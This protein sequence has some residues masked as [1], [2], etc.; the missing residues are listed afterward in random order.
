MDN[1]TFKSIIDDIITNM[2]KQVEKMVDIM[3]KI[4]D[5]DSKNDINEDDIEKLNSVSE[6]LYKAVEH[7]ND[8]YLMINNNE[9][10]MSTED[11]LRLKNLKNSLKINKMF[12]P[13]M[14]LMKIKLDNL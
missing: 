12:M 10:D 2:K 9:I 7:I 14:M 3:D 11:K 8:F 1:Y 6:N 13:Y 4:I 5:M